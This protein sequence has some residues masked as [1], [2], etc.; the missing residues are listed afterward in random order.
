MK[1]ID[2]FRNRLIIFLIQTLILNLF[3]FYFGYH[4][5]LSFN[6]LTTFEQKVI[7]QF[8]ANYT[9]FDVLPRL[10]FIYIIWISVSLIPIFIYN[11]FKKSY[12]MNLLTYFFP[13]FFVYVLLFR[14]SHDFFSAN[15]LFHFINTILL[16]IMI[17]IISIGL[18]FIIKKILKAKVQHQIE[19]LQNIASAGKVICP[20][21]G[22][23]FESIPKFCYNCNTDL[24]I[25]IE[26]KKGKEG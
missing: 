14:Y 10:L 15:F 2:V 1:I 6:I 4:I 8:F 17:V 23:E 3:V 13:N 20:K 12:T 25:K 22:V 9:L 11:D 21:C 24:T 5:N 16:G 18:S 19:N 7:I 26:D